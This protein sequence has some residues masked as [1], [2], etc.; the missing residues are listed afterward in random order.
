MKIAILSDGIYPYSIGGIQKYSFYLTKHLARLGHKVLLISTIG[1]NNKGVDQLLGEWEHK[2][3]EFVG[4]DKYKLPYFPGHYI[5]ESY[6]V[7]KSIY[8]YLI[9]VHDIDFIYSQGFTG[10]AT[11]NNKMKNHKLPPVGVNLHGYNMYF[12]APT[13]SAFLQNII[14]RAVTKKLVNNANYTFSLGCNTTKMLKNTGIAENRIVQTSNAIDKS[15]ISGVYNGKNEVLKFLF[16][17]RYERLKGVEELNKAI[18]KIHNKYDFEFNF[19]GNL[20]QELKLNL[21]GIKYW[22]AINEEDR[23]KRIMKECDVIVLPSYSEGMPSVILEG[24]GMGLAVIATNVGEI[25]ALVSDDN[26]WLIEPGDV[27]LLSKTLTEA[28]NTPKSVL[29]SKKKYSQEL[30]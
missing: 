6:L 23:V 24:M 2:N 26:G 12:K 21:S 9:Q 29:N 8:D 19:I 14:F 4:I 3:I 10:W 20:P 28:V 1:T 30:V 13:L 18:K 16:I 7:S 25:G 17:G 15:W 27:E 5:Y 11:I 22:G